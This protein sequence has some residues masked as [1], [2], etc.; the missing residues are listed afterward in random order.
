MDADEQFGTAT[1]HTTSFLRN[2]VDRGCARM[3]VADRGRRVRVAA[4]QLLAARFEAPRLEVEVTLREA[5]H[6]STH[7][8]ADRPPL[9]DALPYECPL[10]SVRFNVM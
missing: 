9:V 7:D 1:A 8:D 6:Q 5:A 4:S 2:V 10:A 3:R